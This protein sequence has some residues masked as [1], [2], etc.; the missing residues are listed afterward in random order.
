MLIAMK[1]VRAIVYWLLVCCVPLFIITSTIRWGVNEIRVYEYGVDTY[2]ISRVSGIAKPE[3]IKVYQHLI[4]YY[5]SKVDT[6]QVMVMKGGE[7]FTVFS[8]EEV[9]HL[10][11]VKALMQLD[12]TVQ[13]V[14]LILIV[15]CVLVLLLWL[16]DSWRTVVKGLWWGSVVMFGLMIFLALWA[17]FGFEQLFLL[18]HLLSFSNEFWIID[19]SRGSFIVLFPGGFFYDVALFGFGAVIVE[20]LVLGGIAFGALKLKGQGR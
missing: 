3:L 7:R 17:V 14:T 13:I 18:F 16:R 10:G 6:A 20:S 4:D 19:P 12:Y 2:Q 11:D 1:I 8:E 15:F 5:N 9:I